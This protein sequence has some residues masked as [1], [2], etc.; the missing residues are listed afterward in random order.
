MF[1]GTVPTKCGRCQPC[2]IQNAQ[3]WTGRQI[4]ESYLHTGSCFATLTYNDE[5]NPGIVDKAVLRRFID[6]LRIN[7][8]GRKT[9]YYAVGEYGSK[10]NRPHYHLSLFGWSASDLPHLQKSWQNGFVRLDQFTPATA[11]YTCG[12]ILKEKTK[13]NKAKLRNLP[14]EFSSKTPG[15]G[16]GAMTIIADALHST[17]GLNEMERLG[18]VPYSI[19]I[20]KRSLYLGTYLR[21]KLRDEM[22]FSPTQKEKITQDFYD[23]KTAELLELQETTKNPLADNQELFAAFSRQAALNLTTRWKIRKAKYL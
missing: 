3:L 15:L 1:N 20:G 8:P 19:K 10:T 23:L 22:G 18:D 4:L 11:A 17:I 14:P 5:N 13:L 6:R 7:L 21:K 16:K 9:P 2:R 12:Y